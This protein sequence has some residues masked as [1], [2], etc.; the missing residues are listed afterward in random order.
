[1]PKMQS[2]QGSKVIC[3]GGEKFEPDEDGY[4]DV[5]IELGKILLSHGFIEIES[6]PIRRGRPRKNVETTVDSVET[7]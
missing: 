2:T 6:F 5:P 3:H 7:E 4:F 1:M